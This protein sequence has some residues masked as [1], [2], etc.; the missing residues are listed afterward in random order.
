[1]TEYVYSMQNCKLVK[2][3]VHTP[4]DSRGVFF[5][6]EA[7][8]PFKLFQA[9]LGSWYYKDANECMA[10]AYQEEK[11]AI[12]EEELELAQR[13]EALE[14]AKRLLPETLADYIKGATS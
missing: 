2:N 6:K 8:Y 10:A 7:V 14:D 13:R 5:A 1:M 3:K 11:D 9:S 12:L 4:P